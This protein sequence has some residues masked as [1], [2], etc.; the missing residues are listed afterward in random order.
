MSG[1]SSRLSWG[2][3]AM[4]TEPEETEQEDDRDRSLDLGERVGEGACSLSLTQ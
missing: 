3:L 1:E 2:E 4:M